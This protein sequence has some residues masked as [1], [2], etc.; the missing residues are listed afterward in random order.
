MNRAAQY[1]PLAFLRGQEDRLASHVLE[2]LTH[3]SSAGTLVHLE[4]AGIHL[5]V[6][7]LTWDSEY[8]G[9]ATY[10]LDFV[11]GSSN[12]SVIPE[13]LSAALTKLDQTLR[14][15]H[16]QYYLFAEIPSEDISVLQGLGMVGM[17][18]IE[19]RLTYFREDIDTFQWP[20]RSK[21]RHAVEADI[22]N[23]RNTAATMRN[24]YDR[25][26][27]DTSY[28]PDRA[29]SFLATFTENSVR[30]Y[31]DVVL[32]PAD[33]GHYPG[34]F[35]TAKR[36][37]EES[38]LI[39]KQVGRMVLSAVEPSRSGW[40]VRLI[41]EMTYWMKGQGIQVALMTTQSTNRTVIRVWEKIGYHYGRCTHILGRHYGS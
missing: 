12:A 9:H 15:R 11:E 22:P 13:A 10:R 18:L 37:P 25:F 5:W 32:V 36:Q 29:D 40:Y 41:V 3:A 23:L 30:G 26:H 33:Q 21:V 28:A 35:L 4:H 24:T 38:A 14:A 31:A 1:S 2:K 6:N 27:A 19:T 8:F 39:G 17:R 16:G 20:R 7:H 34:A